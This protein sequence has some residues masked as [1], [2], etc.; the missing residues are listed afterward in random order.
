MTGRRERTR[1]TAEDPGRA[2]LVGRADALRLVDKTLDRAGKGTF[3]LLEL[4][5]EPGVGKSRLLAEAVSAARGRAMLT[6]LG[7]ASE[8]E[9]DAPL[10]AIADALDDHLETLPE[11]QLTRLSEGERRLLGS[12]FAGIGADVPAEAPDRYRLFRAV[13]GLLELLAESGGLVLVLDDVHWADESSVELL[14]HLLRHAPR[15]RIVVAVAYR[16]GQASPQLSAAL[17]LAQPARRVRV[18]VSPLTEQ[19]TEELLGPEVNRTRR[20]WLYEA[21]GG[22]PFYLEALSRMNNGRVPAPRDTASEAFASM[23]AEVPDAVRA[24][25]LLELT[26][27]S[28]HGQL[29][30]K[31]AAVVGDEFEPAAVAAAGEIAESDALTALDELVARDVVRPDAARFRFRHPLV[32]HAAYAS[33]KAGWR[34][35]AHGRAA[36]FLRGKG[37]QPQMLAHHVVNSA[38]FGD[39]VSVSELASAA[40][41]VVSRAPAT[42][43]H[44]LGNALRL[45]PENEAT[46]P[47]RCNL[48]LA[49]AN[50]QLSSGQLSG[51]RET[52]REALALL[53][54][55]DLARRAVAARLCATME[56][57]LGSRE[58]AKAVLLAELRKLP[59]PL[60]VEAAP[61]YLRL[62]VEYI[63]TGE[64]AECARM[65]AE[66]AKLD[67]LDPATAFATAALGVMPAYITGDIPGAL[68]LLD[69]V[70]RLM[71]QLTV[72]EIAPWMDITAWLCWA[73]MMVGR[74]A[75]AL[76]R[77]ERA[78]EIARATGQ[79]FVLAY[80]LAAKAFALGRLGRLAEAQPIAE[81]AC[82]IARLVGAPEAQTMALTAQSLVLAWSGE[83]P[84]ALKAASESARNNQQPSKVYWSVLSGC[85]RSL[86]LI[87]SR[88]LEAGRPAVLAACEEFESEGVR[89]ETLLLI[90]LEAM[91]HAE[92]IAGNPSAALPLVDRADAIR[93][94]DHEVNVAVADLIRAHAL[95]VADPAA[96]AKLALQSAETLAGLDYRL[97]EGRARLRAGQSL[98]TS[99]DRAAGL[100]QL[101]TAAELFA[102][103]GARGL[104]AQAAEAQRRLGQRVPVPRAG[105]RQELPFGLSQREFEV[106]RLVVDGRTNAQIAERLS[107]S[108]RTVETHLTRIFSKTGVPARGG[109]GRVLGPYLDQ[110]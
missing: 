94:P 62:A 59:N 23:T 74:H 43:A 81:E 99:G 76:T 108:L 35:G 27:L 34:M 8:F 17:G 48:L 61:L 86:V 53:P 15:G 102:T 1:G 22:N 18:D 37:A 77:L 84:A 66:M 54:V 39:L 57:M 49:L 110:S 79:Q 20:Q 13:R 4:V 55:E 95:S 68:D 104:H 73:E 103:A 56:R 92:A 6:L 105:R 97:E 33:A 82:D 38:P 98:A 106:A 16:P 100:K 101:A 96:S 5:G 40:Q 90:C 21:S 89:D 93:H 31:A 107:L 63:G 65:L 60:V 46:R 41:A 83:Y 91:A 51:G 75:P 9:R 24:A 58:A 72:P 36:H 67:H 3:Q 7:R 26:S 64:A 42:A 19:E 47:T 14:D 45:L 80:L 11:R 29:V 32:R 12:V 10:A 85:A 25:L 52:A 87:Y 30:A 78:I 88:D 69:E 50:A 44:W 109:L 70:D 2:T 28:A 71:S